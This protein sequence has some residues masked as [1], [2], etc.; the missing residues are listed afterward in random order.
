MILPCP[1]PK[2]HG[3]QAAS[4]YASSPAAAFPAGGGRPCCGGPVLPSLSPASPF[5]SRESCDLSSETDGEKKERLT[6][7][8][9][10]SNLMSARI[11]CELV[12][13]H[14][15]PHLPASDA[16]RSGVGPENLHSNKFRGDRGG[17]AGPRTTLRTAG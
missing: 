14:L 7:S 3:V 2:L 6:G 12:K 15:L 8:E 17:T 9:W 11:T 1:S 10:F 16:T 13:T 5:L 4:T